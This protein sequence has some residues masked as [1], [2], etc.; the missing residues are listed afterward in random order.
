[1]LWKI[2]V[3]QETIN[4]QIKEKCDEKVR[5]SLYEAL[6]SRLIYK[7]LEVLLAELFFIF[8][9]FALLFDVFAFF[10]LF[11]LCLKLEVRKRKHEDRKYKEHEENM[12]EAWNS[13]TIIT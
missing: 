12:H 1:M 4:Y 5:V 6:K 3:C 7:E 8:V 13:E 10:T 2:A 9:L 11:I